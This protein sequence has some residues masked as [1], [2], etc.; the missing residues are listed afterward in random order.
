MLKEAFEMTI[1]FQFNFE[2]E[3]KLSILW[4]AYAEQQLTKKNWY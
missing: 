3:H 2:K 1:D 4:M